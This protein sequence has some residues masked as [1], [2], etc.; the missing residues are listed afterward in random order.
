MRLHLNDRQK[1]K[2][3]HWKK[4]VLRKAQKSNESWASYEKFLEKKCSMAKERKSEQKKTWKWLRMSHIALLPL[5]SKC[6]GVSGVNI[7]C[8]K[9]LRFFFCIS[10]LRS[11]ERAFVSSFGRS[12][13]RSF[14]LS[15][16]ILSLFFWLLLLMSFLSVFFYF[17]LGWCFSWARSL[18]LL[19]VVI[20]A[21]NSSFH[22]V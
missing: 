7:I 5:M 19:S 2:C 13:V 12:V 9:V 8:E 6:T 10:F 15:F 18:N 22:F 4:T 20:Y 17:F 3:G 21:A 14:S 1:G 11:F 16:C